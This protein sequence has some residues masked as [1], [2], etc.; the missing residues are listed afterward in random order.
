M[1]SCV[2]AAKDMP[3]CGIGAALQVE[4]ERVSNAE[5]VCHRDQTPQS[6]TAEILFEGN[7][8][9]LVYPRPPDAS[10]PRLFFSYTPA[11]LQHTEVTKASVKACCTSRVST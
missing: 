9:P 8:T 2:A 5:L 6:Y 1:H 3:A 11:C 7:G 4:E 10:Q